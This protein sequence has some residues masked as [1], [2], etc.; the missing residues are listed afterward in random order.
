M[1]DRSGSAPRVLMGKRHE[2]HKFM[3]GMFVFP[4]GRAE[5]SDAAVPVASELLPVVQT[6]L[7][8][9]CQRA[10]AA[11]ARRLALAAIRETFEETGFV[12]GLPGLAAANGKGPWNEFLS[13]G[14]LPDLGS[15]RFLARAITPPGRT[16][17]FDTRFFVV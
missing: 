5:R 2:G 12:I 4:G 7:M 1:V 10:T 16:K 8:A 6:S 17:R 3:P 13:T 14:H 9:R 11:R 15:I